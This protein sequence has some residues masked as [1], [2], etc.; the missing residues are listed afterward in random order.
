MMCKDKL[1]WY[2]FVTSYTKYTGIN[3]YTMEKKNDCRID[4]LPIRDALYVINGKWK[5]QIIA[6]LFNGSL[7]FKNLQKEV[8]G[9]TSRMLSRELKEMEI[10]KLVKRTVNDTSPV[11][12][13]YELTEYAMSLNKVIEE[14]HN[15]GK[16]HRGKIMAN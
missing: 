16:L 11:S 2:T 6:T 14:L 3:Y 7:R 4:L 9:I 8:S 5:I 10:N 12:V 13:E 15:W 1:K